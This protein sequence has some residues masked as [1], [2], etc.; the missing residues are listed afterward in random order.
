MSTHMYR[1]PLVWMRLQ[2]RS[3]AFFIAGVANLLQPE[4]LINKTKQVRDILELSPSCEII[5][6]AARAS[7]EVILQ[8]SIGE[9]LD[10]FPKRNSIVVSVGR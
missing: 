9:D 1:A 2:S 3:S 6:C 10:T 8:L 4:P 7:Q 5:G